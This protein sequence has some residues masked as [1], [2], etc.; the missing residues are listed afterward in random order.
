ME[1]TTGY[2]KR[3]VYNLAGLPVFFAKRWQIQPRMQHLI[4]CRDKMPNYKDVTHQIARSKL[5]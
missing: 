5:K 4:I 3:V 2:K 1:T